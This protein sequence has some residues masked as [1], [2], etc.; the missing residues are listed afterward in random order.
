MVAKIIADNIEGGTNATPNGHEAPGIV[1]SAEQALTLAIGI[2]TRILIEIQ[3]CGSQQIL[4]GL[5]VN[6]NRTQAIFQLEEIRNQ[7]HYASFHG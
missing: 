4:S 2:A 1:L 7:R 6:L 5:S 3:I